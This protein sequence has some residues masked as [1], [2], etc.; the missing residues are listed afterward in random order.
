M[1]GNEKCTAKRPHG[2]WK[3]KVTQQSRRKAHGNEN[4][5][6]KEKKTLS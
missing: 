3:S 2:A 6:G 1:H 5:H 4:A